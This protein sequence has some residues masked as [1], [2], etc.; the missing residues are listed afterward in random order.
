MRVS[1][2]L[3]GGG[4]PPG[5]EMRNLSTA[6]DS[7]PHLRGRTQL[8]AEGH[9]APGLNET[10]TTLLVDLSPAA[11]GAFS[12]IVLTWIRHRTGTA[13]LTVRRPDGAR[14][15]L[16]AQRVRNLNADQLATLATQLTEA[17]TPTPPPPD[18]AQPTRAGQLTAP[19][20]Q[21][22]PPTPT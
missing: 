21:P 13:R 17:L 4:N 12:T 14:L 8:G 3:D 1:L 15:E 22:E 6:L 2:R 11:L 9:H 19:T 10:L 5:P 16:S 7:H 18:G 20:N